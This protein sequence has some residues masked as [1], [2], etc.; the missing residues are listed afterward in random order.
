[1]NN[2]RNVTLAGVLGLAVIAVASWLLVLSPR[3]GTSSDLEAQADAIAA[4][5]VATR[6]A[7]RE[8]QTQS[9]QLPRFEDEASAL[10]TMF[11]PDIAQPELYDLLRAAAAAAGLPEQAI[12]DVA[13]TVPM[14]G[15][16]DGSVTLPGAAAPSAAATDPDAS[17]DAA[18]GT[19]PPTTAG[20]ATVAVSSVD[21]NVTGP[22]DRLL[23]F[24]RELENLDRTYLMT[25]LT[26]GG[27]PTGGATANSYTLTVSGNMFMLP[28][29]LDP[30]AAAKKAET[31][32]EQAAPAGTTTQP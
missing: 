16:T 15:G 19:T 7:I 11:P 25:D 3:M 12:T 27:I 18:G 28:P 32:A 13:P 22:R 20:Q 1:M 10:S 26:M 29:L 8:L 4:S 9:D 24:V 6:A 17:T 2:K 5:N 23:R 30:A 21:L 31:D 14:V